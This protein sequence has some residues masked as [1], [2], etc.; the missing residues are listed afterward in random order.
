MAEKANITRIKASDDAPKAKSTATVKAKVEK[1]AT[2]SPR[3][4][5][6]SYGIRGGA[7]LKR[8][9][10]Y[11]KGAWVE[12]R[13]VRW[14]NRQATWSLTAAVVIFSLLLTVLILAL[15]ALFKFLFQLIIG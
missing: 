1:R 15:D 14:P 9:G 2:K 4:S 3:H 8:I 5:E 12:L 10:A 7:T 11:F 6:P 13:Q